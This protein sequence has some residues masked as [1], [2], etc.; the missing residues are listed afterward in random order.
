MPQNSKFW[1]GTIGM[2]TNPTDPVQTNTPFMRIDG[3]IM[4]NTDKVQNT[5][6]QNIRNNASTL[7][8]WSET[9]EGTLNMELSAIDVVFFLLATLWK[10]TTTDVSS[11]TDGTVFEH[12]IE[13]ENC[14]LPTMSVEIKKGGCTSWSADPSGQSTMVTRW[15]GCMMNT[16]T[17]NIEEWILTCNAEINAYGAFDVAQLIADPTW[18]TYKFKKWQIRGLVVGDICRLYESNTETFEEVTISAIDYTADTVT[19]TAVTSVLFTVANDTKLELVQKTVN[20]DSPQLFG[21]QNARVRIADTLANAA[22]A[23][24]TAVKTLNLNLWNNLQVDTQTEY[25]TVKET[26]S[27]YTVDMTLLYEN[28]KIRDARRNNT[29]QAMIIEIDNAKII[30]ATDTN[31]ETFSIRFEI[32]KFEYQTFEAPTA[33]GA[34]IEESVVWL[35]LYDDVAEKSITAKVYNDKANNYYV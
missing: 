5:S 8:E 11:G 16:F 13:E 18:T 32:N 7:V 22:T 17:L 23:E 34:L 25:N 31:N 19:F 20:Y 28:N 10:L 9:T 24:P 26:W 1:Y 2:Q 4:K 30:S 35:I 33:T 14:D 3:D 21:F 15:Y 29:Q 27:D 6:I 12:V